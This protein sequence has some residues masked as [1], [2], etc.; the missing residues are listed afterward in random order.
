MDNEAPTSGNGDVSA[1]DPIDRIEAFLAAQDG[2]GSQAG[3][4]P[5]Q[6]AADTPDDP[7]GDDEGKTSEPQFTTAHLAQ[8]LGVD[9]SLVDVDAD[10]QPVFK[11]KIDGKEGTAKFQDFL[12]D[13]QLKGH[14]ENRV[15]EAAAREAAADRKLQEADQV[16]HQRLQQAQNDLQQV[17][18]LAQVA[19]EEL[20]RDYNSVNWAELR[21]QD[22]GRAALLEMEFQKRNERIKSVFAD[23]N[24]R[25]SQAA[26]QAE[27]QRRANEAQNAQR[28]AV[29]L[30]ELIPEWKDQ[31]VA[32]RENGEIRAWLQST[33]AESTELDLSKAA[34]WP[35]LRRA[36]QH[37]T[38]QKSKP[39]I[40]KQLRAAPKLVKPGAAAQ[41]GDT[42]NAAQ[43]KNL[44]QQARSTGGNST[45]ATA[46]WLIANGL[47]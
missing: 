4:E 12:K 41:A 19:H 22:A 15:R 17:Q 5:A 9:E 1:A 33:G 45:K 27:H 40:E 7:K 26:Q 28:Q 21:A 23:T 32:A 6:N 25:M 24:N 39:E 20:N 10:G 37:D 16:I 13:H 43:L 36:W 44:K 14:A 46:A 34:L 42:S 11:T 29:R 3:N 2:D 31:A 38:L 18:Q 35:L 47:A 30:F 8:F